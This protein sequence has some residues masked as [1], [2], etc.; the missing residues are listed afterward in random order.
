MAVV[1]SETYNSNLNDFQCN[2]LY[3][4][5]IPVNIALYCGGWSNVLDAKPGTKSFL[6]T[7]RLKKRQLDKVFQK[8]KE[9]SEKMPRWNFI[10]EVG[11]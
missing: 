8:L 3:V 10:R 11:K 5:E 9:Q 1:L 7:T 2:E 4:V 6:I